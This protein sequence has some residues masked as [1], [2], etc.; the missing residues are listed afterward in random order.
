[1]SRTSCNLSPVCT[2]FS[3]FPPCGATVRCS[4]TVM[5]LD[6]ISPG[7]SDCLCVSFLSVADFGWSRPAAGAGLYRLHQRPGGDPGDPAGQASDDAV[8]RHIDR[9]PAGAEEHRH[10][11]TVL[12]GE[13]I[14]VSDL[15]L[16]RDL[17]V[18]HGPVRN[19]I[20]LLAGFRLGN[21]VC[22]FSPDTFTEN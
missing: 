20:K 10:E 4:V 5:W 11:R 17:Q 22:R 3:I 19:R 8:Q 2:L 16:S 18:I 14:G 15:H 7:F 21:G 13:Q 9:H 1:M 6:I 12:L